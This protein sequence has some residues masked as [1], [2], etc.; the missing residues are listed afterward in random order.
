MVPTACTKYILRVMVVTGSQAQKTELLSYT[1]TNSSAFKKRHFYTVTE[2]QGGL[3][4]AVHINDERLRIMTTEFTLKRQNKGTDD[5]HMIDWMAIC[6]IN[7]C[8]INLCNSSYN[9]NWMS[10]LPVILPWHLLDNSRY[11]RQF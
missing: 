2:Q 1:H 11:H 5:G 3:K 8:I 9:W 6:L 4:L 7:K 10:S